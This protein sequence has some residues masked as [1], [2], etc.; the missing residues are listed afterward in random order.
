MS[1]LKDSVAPC[2]QWKTV[3]RQYDSVTCM[4]VKCSQVTLKNVWNTMMC[5]VLLI[6]H[7]ASMVLTA[8]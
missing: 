7:H 6:V 8:V 3:I 4:I 1:L 2:G 5:I